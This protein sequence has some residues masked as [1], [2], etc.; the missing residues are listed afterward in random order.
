VPKRTG[1]PGRRTS[2]EL[3]EMDLGFVVVRTLVTSEVYILEAPGLRDGADS[4]H[5]MAVDVASRNE[6]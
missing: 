3:P 6:P 4:K 5:G 2:P 1:Q